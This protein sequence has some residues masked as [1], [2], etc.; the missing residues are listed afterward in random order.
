M[1]FIAFGGSPSRA[2]GFQFLFSNTF[3]IYRAIDKQFQK[4]LPANASC[5]FSVYDVFS[6]ETTKI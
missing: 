4:Q 3:K 5:Q 1:R 6:N 2:K